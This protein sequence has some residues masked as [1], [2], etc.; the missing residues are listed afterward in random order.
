MENV[1]EEYKLAARLLAAPEQVSLSDFDTRLKAVRAPL[2]LSEAEW[3]LVRGL[4]LRIDGSQA[5]AGE[6]FRAAEGKASSS[7][8]WVLTVASLLSRPGSHSPDEDKKEVEPKVEKPD[9]KPEPKPK[10][11]KPEVKPEPKPPVAPPNT[12]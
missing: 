4:R 3:D 2:L 10:V 11:D 6:A 8:S 7:R 5:A 9:V 1:A 12:K